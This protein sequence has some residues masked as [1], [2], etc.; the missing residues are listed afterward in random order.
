MQTAYAGA[1]SSSALPAYDS[2]EKLKP[3]MHFNPQQ[4]YF[5]LVDRKPRKGR[6]NHLGITWNIPTKEQLQE[7]LL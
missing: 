4:S 6:G 1:C 7:L 5:L 3:W 2:S